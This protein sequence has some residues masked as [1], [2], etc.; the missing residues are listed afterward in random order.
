[1]DHAC[2]VGPAVRVT[3]PHALSFGE[4]WLTE[5]LPNVERGI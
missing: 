4:G 3:G 2:E 1:M 5:G